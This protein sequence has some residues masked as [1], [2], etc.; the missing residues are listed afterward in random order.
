MPIGEGLVG[1]RRRMA[2]RPVFDRPGGGP[3]TGTP[4]RTY[5]KVINTRGNAALVELR[6]E[7]G[8][9]HQ[10]RVHTAFGLSC[11]ILGDHKYDHRDKLAP[12]VR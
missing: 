1:D 7:T 4:A 10:L 6:P 12:Q 9:K 3:K 5:Y 2:L 8:I 11:G